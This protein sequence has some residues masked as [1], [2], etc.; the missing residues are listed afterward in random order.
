M[1][2]I[3]EL[4]GKPIKC[5]PMSDNQ[6][7]QL[8]TKRRRLKQ[9]G[10]IYNLGYVMLVTSVMFSHQFSQDFLAELPSWAE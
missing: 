10:E 2:N 3:H 9:F 8:Q 5:F 1:E 7:F 4:Q 6:L